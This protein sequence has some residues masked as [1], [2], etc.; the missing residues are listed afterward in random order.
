MKIMIKYFLVLFSF[1]SLMM[2]AFAQN[3][4]AENEVKAL[5]KKQAQDWNNGNLEAFM[6]GYWKSDKLQFIGSRGITYGWQQTFENY[7]KA[8]PDKATM[9]QLTFELID[10]SQQSRKVVSVTGKF[11]LKRENI[12]DSS[13]HFLL[14]VKKIKGEWLIIADHTS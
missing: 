1:I 9:G 13:G 7:K 3:N 4:K 6:Q 5:L 14:I 10:V 8:Y 12:D 2:P 11:M